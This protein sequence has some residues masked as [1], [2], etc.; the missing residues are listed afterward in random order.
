MT[1]RE[2]GRELDALVAVTLMGVTLVSEDAGIRPAAMSYQK[3]SEVLPYSTDVAAAWQVVE[4]MRARGFALELH[5]EFG[6]SRQWVADFSNDGWLSTG[7][8]LGDTAPLAICR[9]A[10][11][12]VEAA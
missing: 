1:A 12:A 8:Q 4:R 2:A 3:P 6:W 9:A 7:E 5:Y 11:A 10:L